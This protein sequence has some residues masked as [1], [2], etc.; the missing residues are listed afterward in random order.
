MLARWGVWKRKATSTEEQVE[1][2]GTHVSNFQVLTNRERKKIKGAWSR[3]VEGEAFVH[4]HIVSR[5]DC[6]IA[7]Y[8]APVHCETDVLSYHCVLADGSHLRP[9]PPE[10]IRRWLTPSWTR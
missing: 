8:S 7:D 10:A 5:A 4:R 9:L 2:T 1:T 6:I 3:Y